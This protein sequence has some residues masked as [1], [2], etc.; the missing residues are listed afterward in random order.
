MNFREK[1]EKIHKESLEENWRVGL[2]RD[3]FLFMQPKIPELLE[4]L[5]ALSDYIRETENIKTYAFYG[6]KVLQ[7]QIASKIYDERLKPAMKK[8]NEDTNE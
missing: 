2:I 4:L 7:A 3:Y 5:N 1:L 8:L 6:Q